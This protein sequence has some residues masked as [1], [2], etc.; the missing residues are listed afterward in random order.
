MVVDSV[1]MGSVI[2]IAAMSTVTAY[3]RN[4]P[5]GLKAGVAWQSLEICLACT[6]LEHLKPSRGLGAGN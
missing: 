4:I 3:S 2:L 1:S 5:C 6:G